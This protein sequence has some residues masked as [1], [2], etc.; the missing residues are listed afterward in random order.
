[1]NIL[2]KANETISKEVWKSPIDI[3]MKERLVRFWEPIV[4]GAA[5]A[6]VPFLLFENRIDPALSIAIDVFIWSVFTLAFVSVLLAC[7]GWPERRA[8]LMQSWLEILIIVCSFP[9]F[10]TSWASLRTLRLGRLL[11]LSRLFAITY[12]LRWTKRRF[13]LS[14]VTFAG[15]TA[16]VTAVLG[17]NA[18]HVIE[19]NLA[20][21]LGTGL[22]WAITTM[23]TVGYGDISPATLQ[24]RL[25]GSFLMVFGVAIMASFSGYLA[26]FL[27]TE[28]DEHQE[29]LKDRLV[30]MQ[31]KLDMLEELLRSN[32]ALKYPDDGTKPSLSA[33]VTTA[34]PDGTGDA[35]SIVE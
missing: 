34:R 29:E 31:E 17:A 12:L 3:S 23:T 8:W 21:D 4:G 1:M 9:L 14:P 28:N 24:G 26:S 18:L 19:P 15:A 27:V 33:V 30:A 13:A 22:W 35:S 16:V 32:L 7:R 11:R 20:P 5:L 6:T 25:V 10:P 2:A